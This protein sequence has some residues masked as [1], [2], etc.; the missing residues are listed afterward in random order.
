M[1]REQK[2]AKSCFLLFNRSTKKYDLVNLLNPG[3]DNDAQN[4]RNDIYYQSIGG[5]N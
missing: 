5:G 1:E 3:F 4:K 2:A